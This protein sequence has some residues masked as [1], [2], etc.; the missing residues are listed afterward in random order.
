MYRSTLDLSKSNPDPASPAKVAI[1]FPGNGIGLHNVASVFLLGK[2][3][4]SARK[5]YLRVPAF[6]RMLPYRQDGLR[7][8]WRRSRDDVPCRF[9][10]SSLGTAHQPT[11]F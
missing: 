4:G 7:G 10:P 8:Q 3:L 11:A 5:A 6:R 2:S 9:G 1:K